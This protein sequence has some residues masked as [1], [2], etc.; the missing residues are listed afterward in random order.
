MEW[1]V[2][3]CTRGCRA[4]KTNQL[5][6]SI[7]LVGI[8]CGGGGGDSETQLIAKHVH[9]WL[10]VSNGEKFLIVYILV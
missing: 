2:M 6:A 4:I 8:F 7:V 1:Q 5:S 10:D 9:E 3:N